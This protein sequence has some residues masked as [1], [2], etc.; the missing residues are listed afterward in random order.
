MLTGVSSK[1]DSDWLEG[2]SASRQWWTFL[3]FLANNILS[4]QCNEAIY[5][6][7]ICLVL[8]PPMY[9]NISGPKAPV[10]TCITTE[11]SSVMPP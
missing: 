7:C 8:Q 2:K 6:C 9:A 11:C 1:L 5:M 4:R 3:W 10:K